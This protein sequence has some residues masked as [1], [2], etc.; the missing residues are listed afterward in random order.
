[1][2]L[3]RWFYGKTDRKCSNGFYQTLVSERSNIA[4]TRNSK[5]K[6]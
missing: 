2:L 1:L 6:L 5:F 4:T 3:R